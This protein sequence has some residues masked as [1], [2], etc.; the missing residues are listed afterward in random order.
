MIEIPQVAEIDHFEN[1]CDGN[2]ILVFVRAKW[3]CEAVF[4]GL[5]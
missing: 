3:R 2:E 4:Q 1:A 5:V